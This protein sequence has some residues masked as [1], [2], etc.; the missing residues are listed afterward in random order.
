MEQLNFKTKKEKERAISE[1]YWN[2]FFSHSA[3]SY[4]SHYDSTELWY[5]QKYGFG[6]Y[7]NYES[8]RVGK[9]TYLKKLGQENGVSTRKRR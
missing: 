2:Y 8:F 9:T 7:V 4:K 3:G 1:D 6:K 5:T